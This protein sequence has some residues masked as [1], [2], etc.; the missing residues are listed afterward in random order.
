[1]SSSCKNLREELISCILDESNCIQLHKKSFHECLQKENEG[2]VPIRCSQL[3]QAYF[4]CKRQ[5]LDMRYRFKGNQA[6]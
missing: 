5:M 4:E 6:A 2:S 3:K 1:M